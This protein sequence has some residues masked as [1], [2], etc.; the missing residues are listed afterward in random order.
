MLEVILIPLVIGMFLSVNMGASGIAPAFSA[1]YGADLLRKDLIPVLF[2]IF[3]FLGAIFG[4]RAVSE[5]IGRGFLAPEHFTLTVTVVVLLSVSIA[6]LIANLIGVP[7][8]T[9][10][11]AVLAVVGA[12]LY[13][14]NLMSERLLYQILPAWF[15][16][17]VAAFLSIFI[18][19]IA[20]RRF[21]RLQRYRHWFVFD[22]SDRRIRFLVIAVSCYAAFSIGSNNVANASGILASMMVNE[23][24]LGSGNDVYTVMLIIST[25]ICAPLFGIGG[26]VL[27]LK[28]IERTGKK[29]ISFGP[30][31]ALLISLITGTLL[32][33]AS[34]AGIPASEVQL[35]TGAI[36]GLALAK[37]SLKET[38]ENKSVRIIL[39]VWVIAPLIAGGLAYG[40][41]W[42]FDSAGILR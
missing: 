30:L 29:I 17:P 9:S 13:L 5:T 41:M 2:G 19:G 11:A 23:L 26:S 35:G 12:A 34:I 25:L 33:G 27:G 7:Q 14:E 15:I 18:F 28:N 39:S 38:F 1:A 42:V 21:R 10:Q 36:I 3:V 8:S 24:R 22:P 31:G 6:L 32:L 37:S 4:G 40:L 16:M 20:F